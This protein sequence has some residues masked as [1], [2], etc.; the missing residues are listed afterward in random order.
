MPT[1]R[2]ADKTI[3][4]PEEAWT[5]VKQNLEYIQI[6]G[7][8]ISIYI[9]SEKRSKSDVYKTWNGK[10]IGYTDITKHLKTWALKTH[11]VLIA[12]EP[13]VNELKRRAELLVENSMPLPL[14]LLR[15]PAEEPKP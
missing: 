6:F 7:S 15:Q 13:V 3:I 8:R 12:S 4:I 9:P 14:R 10:F 5:E 2:I 1:K 11:Q